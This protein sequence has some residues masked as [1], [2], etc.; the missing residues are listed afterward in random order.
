[1]NELFANCACLGLA[2][3]L[4]SFYLG[5]WLHKKWDNPLTL[6]IIVSTLVCIVVLLLGDVEYETFRKNSEFLTFLLTP[7]TVSLA[8]P[9]YRQMDKLKAHYVAILVG[10]FS[11]VL[12]SGVS[13]LAL[14]ALF[15]MSHGDYVTLLPKS[16]TT[17]IGLSLSEEL[18]GTPAITVVSI[19]IA[20]T[21]GNCLA[22][23]LC[24]LF[25]ITEPIAKGIAIG[26]A[27]HAMGTA[28]AMELGEVEG[29]MSGLSI[30]V[31]GLMTV[32]AAQVFAMLY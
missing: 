28:K 8:I 7:A 31:C 19:I 20:G 29:A 25:R 17:A 11:G 2:L 6:P 14:C 12:A 27:S 15:G 4:G 23:I 26:T 32:V 18:G 1:M 21:G 10:I 16:V 5:T 30:A 9:L 24:K 3:A 13:A 22:P